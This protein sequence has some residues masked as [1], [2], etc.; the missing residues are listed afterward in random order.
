MIPWTRYE[1]T[2]LLLYSTLACPPFC[3]LEPLVYLADL[4]L[5]YVSS[6]QLSHSHS[7]SLSF[8]SCSIY[9]YIYAHDHAVL[10][11]VHLFFF[12]FF[13]LVIAVIIVVVLPLYARTFANVVTY[14][15]A[16]ST[17]LKRERGNLRS[18]E[19]RVS[20]LRRAALARENPKMP[21]ILK[22]SNACTR[23]VCSYTYARR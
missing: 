9:L 3:L 14:S 8:L 11:D 5:P 4:R 6:A 16:K 20:L 12:F 1:F 23:Y 13:F 7:L 18:P 19:E 17:I 21:L 2:F 15:L 22:Y 10:R